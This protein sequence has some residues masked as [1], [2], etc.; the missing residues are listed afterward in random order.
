MNNTIVKMD[1]FYLR[2]LPNDN[3]NVCKNKKRVIGK[4]GQNFE[5]LKIHEYNKLIE[6]EYRVNQLKDICRAYKIKVGGNKKELILRI[7]NYLKLTYCSIKIQSQWRRHLCEQF[8]KK[9]GPAIKNKKICVNETDFL[10]MNDIELLPLKEFFS[11]ED[12]DG[13]VYG[14]D[15]KSIYNLILKEKNQAKNPYNRKPF[16][17]GM[18]QDINYIITIGRALNLEINL[19]MENDNLTPEKYNELRIVDL[20]QAIDDLGNYTNA[21]WFSS[22]TRIHLIRFIR[23]L[24]DIWSYRANLDYT[25][26]R[27]ICPPIGNPFM[28]I[29]INV[30]PNKTQNELREIS[31]LIIERMVKT[32]VNHGSKCLGANYVLCALTLVNV[33]AAVALPWLYQSVAPN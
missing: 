5:I 2:D 26:K 9:H 10:T 18:R 31:L 32:G 24:L 16:P 21:E 30:L 14:F 12:V 23:E 1:D 27:E 15:I 6:N 22:L 19:N 28:G 11:Y 17:K 4:A 7:Y 25:I 20:F 29:N 3:N 8:I 33:D 13:M